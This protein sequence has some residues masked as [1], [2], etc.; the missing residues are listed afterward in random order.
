MVALTDLPTLPWLCKSIYGS[1]TFRDILVS[2]PAWHKIFFA[3]A[4]SAVVVK[5]YSILLSRK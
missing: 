2:W 1:T 3:T 4:W 5:S